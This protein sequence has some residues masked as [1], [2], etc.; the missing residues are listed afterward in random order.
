VSSGPAPVKVPDVTGQ[1]LS[2]AE[3]TLTNAG[4]QVGTVSKRASST[5]SPGTVLSQI[6]AT[7]DSVKAESKVAL[8]VAQAP[9]EA[10]VPDVLGETHVLAEHELE[11]SG[12]KAKSEP[13][14]TSEASQVGMVLHQ[15]PSGGSR[16]A[17]GSSVTIAV[18]VLG[19]TTTPTTPTTTTPPTTPGPGA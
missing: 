10:T 16:A 12:F 15:S 8:V 1:S 5:E 6:P 13:S 18:G 9:K 14:P 2:A 3:A 4:L 19:S 11:L 7:G 17:K